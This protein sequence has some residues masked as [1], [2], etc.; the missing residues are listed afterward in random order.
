MQA[1][2]NYDVVVSMVNPYL[3]WSFLFFLTTSKYSHFTDE[4][5]ITF[6]LLDCSPKNTIARCD[7]HF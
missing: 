2:V 4:Y 5:R 6:S 3:N 1:E 7:Y